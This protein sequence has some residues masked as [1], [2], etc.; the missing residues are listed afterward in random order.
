M[1]VEGFKGY[2]Y[3]NRFFKKAFVGSQP[4]NVASLFVD[5]NGI[6]YAVAA[7]VYKTSS[8][9]S[10]RDRQIL[11]KKS[12]S[13]LEK[14][15]IKQILKEFER[16]IK[17]FK[18]SDNLILAVDGMVNNAKMNQQKHRR[19]KK[20]YETKKEFEI[21]NTIVLTPGT[22]FMV[23]LDQA[24]EEW[25]KTK[26]DILPLRTIYSSHLSP[27]EGEHKIFDYIR[28]GGIILE[29]NTFEN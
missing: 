5:C 19:F 21:F 10:D 27:G 25:I 15:Y 12:H 17:H 3:N 23:K 4:K 28:R 6:F 11:F 22:D 9:Y 20:I 8:D 1:G 29:N 24:I 2:L 26:K 18:P 7:E 13:L 14:K 16:I